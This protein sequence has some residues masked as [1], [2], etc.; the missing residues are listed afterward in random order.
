VRL[1]AISLHE[2]AER[3]RWDRLW[4]HGYDLEEGEQKGAGR[5]AEGGRKGEQKGAHEGEQKMGGR[6]A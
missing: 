6:G 3:Q 4:L 2:L 5:G 1:S